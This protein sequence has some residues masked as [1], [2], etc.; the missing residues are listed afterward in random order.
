MRGWRKSGGTPSDGTRGT[1]GTHGSPLFGMVYIWWGLENSA[2]SGPTTSVCKTADL[3]S[4][5]SPQP[6]TSL[7]Y[8]WHFLLGWPRH[9]L[10]VW[11]HARSP[12]FRGQEYGGW[13]SR[14]NGFCSGSHSALQGTYQ[15]LWSLNPFRCSESLSY[16]EAPVL[17]ALP[18]ASFSKSQDLYHASSNRRGA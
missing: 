2:P 4:A 9:P 8:C 6:F 1:H 12:W 14:Q 3:Y 18:A 11:F 16:S 17:E 7:F 5:H 10:R 13:M 15:H